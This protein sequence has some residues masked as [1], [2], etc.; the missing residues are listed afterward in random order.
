MGAGKTCEG[1]KDVKETKKALADSLKRI[2]LIDESYTGEVT[3]G[4]TNGG[5][6][7]IRK[8]ETLK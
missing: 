8:S 4:I 5:V 6:M 1:A 2:G 3:V 7:F